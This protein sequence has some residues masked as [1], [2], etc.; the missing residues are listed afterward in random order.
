V[1]GLSG[2]SSCTCR[3]VSRIGQPVDDPDV[4]DIELGVAKGFESGD[5]KEDVLVIVAEQFDRLAEL[6]DELTERRVPLF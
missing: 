1:E 2:I 3:I 4:V 6:Q 5:R